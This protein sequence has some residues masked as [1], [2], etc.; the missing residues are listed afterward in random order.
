MWNMINTLWIRWLHFFF[1]SFSLSSKLIYS[2]FPHW[3]VFLA[4]L[5]ID[6]NSTRTVKSAHSLSS[7]SCVCNTASRSYMIRTRIY[8][9]LTHFTFIIDLI[10][11]LL[12][13][14]L[15]AFNQ[16]INFF[17]AHKTRIQYYMYNFL[18]AVIIAK[19]CVMYVCMCGI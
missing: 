11:S 18:I 4:L 17:F 7:K 3:C 9:K 1:F 10:F 16:C 2:C 14:L 8:T 13:S 12:L 5:K 19:K 6:R 15:F